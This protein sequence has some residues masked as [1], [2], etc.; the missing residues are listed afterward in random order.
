MQAV[1]D[2]ITLRAVAVD[3]TTERVLRHWLAVVEADPAQLIRSRRLNCRHCWGKDHA[4]QWTSW[5]LAEKWDE[6]VAHHE[7]LPVV[8]G[9]V[10]FMFNADP[11]P[12]C[13][14]CGGEGVLDVFVADISTV[15][16]KD[17]VLYAGIKQTK[18][19]YEIKM[20]DQ[21]AAWD[22]IRDYLGMVVKRGE[23]TGKN[24][25]PLLPGGKLPMVDEVLPTEPRALEVLYRDITSN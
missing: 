18:D 22:N 16:E 23:L 11:N 25:Q 1:R 5:E 3:L 20:H 24:G 13:P 10:G 21:N 19:G 12:D 2:R 9:G 14:R 15:P 6:A 7:T 4:Y 17:R 8:T